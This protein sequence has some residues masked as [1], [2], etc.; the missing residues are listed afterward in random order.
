MINSQHKMNRYPGLR[1]FETNEGELFFG[2]SREIIELMER[3]KSDIMTVV[4]SKSGYGKSSLINAGINSE[5]IKNNYYPIRIRFQPQRGLDLGNPIN[6]VLEK[7]QFEYE[8]FFQR[9]EKADTE[10]KELIPS[11][12]NLILTIPLNYEKSIPFQLWEHIKLY[13]FPAPFKPIF[14]FDQFEELFGY[15]KEE[16]EKF[17]NQLAELIHEQPPSRVI[18]WL[19]NVAPNY[20]SRTENQMQWVKQPSIKFLFAIRS[21]RLYQLNQVEDFIPLIL[22]NLFELKPLYGPQAKEALIRPA[23]I[24]IPDK[25]SSPIFKYDNATV[26]LILKTLKNEKGEIDSSQL[27]MLCSYIEFAVK[28]ISVNLYTD[29]DYVVDKIIIPDKQTIEGIIAKFYEDQIMTLDESD[30][31]A[32]K[33]MIEDEL[34]EGGQRVGVA[35]SRIRRRLGVRADVILDQLQETRLIRLDET[36][37]GYTFELSHDTLIIP[38]ERSKKK[39]QENETKKLLQLKDEEIA[40]VNETKRI[41]LTGVYVL[42]LVSAV[43]L[44]FLMKTIIVGKENRKLYNSMIKAISDNQYKL[45]RYDLAFRLWHRIDKP[46][47]HIPYFAPFMG[48]RVNISEEGYVVVKYGDN[49]FSVFELIDKVNNK[50]RD[51]Y[52]EQPIAPYSRFWLAGHSLVFVE[53]M[54]NREGKSPTIIYNLK[55]RRRIFKGKMATPT[56][57]FNSLLSPKGL[58]VQLMDTTNRPHLYRIG[59]DTIHEVNSFTNK[60]QNYPNRFGNL[61]K[62]NYNSNERNTL[63]FTNDSSFIF[64]LGLSDSVHVVNNVNSGSYSTSGKFLALFKNKQDIVLI[65]KKKSK[66]FIFFPIDLP[67][68]AKISKWCFNKDESK[69][70]IIYEDESLKSRWLLS[71]NTNEEVVKP[72]QNI[73]NGKC[74]LLPFADRLIIENRD[75]NGLVHSPIIYDLL[76]G[77]CVNFP[78]SKGY[79]ITLAGKTNVILRD[80]L[81]K[82]FLFNAQSGY[83][84]NL[85]DDDTQNSRQFAFL[86]DST[87]DRGLVVRYDKTV[88]IIQFK[89]W[90]KTSI[91]INEYES[92]LIEV[93]LVN[94]KIGLSFNGN[95][96][97][98][99]FLNNDLNNAKFLANYGYPSLSINKQVQ[100][101]GFAQK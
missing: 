6:I 51:I 3:V 86:C 74:W 42:L 29:T 77:K 15:D 11:L 45:G 2:R 73:E 65:N 22:R 9:Y 34:V 14:I 66:P 18:N 78:N 52:F 101:L 68:S 36:H 40:K 39:R 4:F 79:G 55:E 5:L 81:R 17:L 48:R 99:L 43:A 19:L 56:G 57:D 41:Y 88:S 21:D 83:L 76:S 27:Q 7:L 72:P 67:E 49:T 94:N 8:S 80:N 32:A 1:S 46:R 24:N 16:Q 97:I 63:L 30:R 10:N 91:H 12:Q 28:E 100:L 69:L 89:N 82:H 23:L 59:S 47:P 87:T 84:F 31:D 93:K 95:P 44:Y 54:D 85:K 60:L 13:K 35:A 20:E 38:V 58:F 90:L 62:L 26:E 92:K 64:N 98:C 70:I 96:D 33:Y 71:I 61:Y 37:L 25:F 75:K 53:A 50:Y